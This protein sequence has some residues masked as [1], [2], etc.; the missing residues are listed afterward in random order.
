MIRAP[1]DCSVGD[2][3]HV[4]HMLVDAVLQAKR[5]DSRAVVEEF[6]IR[7]AMLRESTF[8][9]LDT[10]LSA[11]IG[12]R[13]H[14]G[15]TMHTAGDVLAQE[16]EA[17]TEV[18]AGY[19]GRAIGATLLSRASAESV[20]DGAFGQYAVLEKMDHFP[21]F[22]PM[23]TATAAGLH[24]SQHRQLQARHAQ[25]WC[26]DVNHD[27]S[28]RDDWLQFVSTRPQ[29]YDT[30]ELAEIRKGEALLL[31]F[32]SWTGTARDVAGMPPTVDKAQTKFDKRTRRLIGRA[33]GTIHGAT[34]LEVCAYL[35][36]F[37]SKHQKAT[38]FNPHLHV[39]WEIREVVNDLC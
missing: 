25:R 13:T 28:Y 36:N 31:A 37:G 2:G 10:L 6:M 17:V 9:H 3:E 32:D 24:F 16:P 35:M 39:I 12:A 22:R 8:K 29:E 38:V 34:P 11:L 19:I 14:G 33:E 26:A 4:G 21:W 15:D 5:E 1:A 23:I 30:K 27:R 18:E 20:V 7:T